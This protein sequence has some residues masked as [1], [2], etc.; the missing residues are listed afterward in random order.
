ME[1]IKSEQLGRIKT[2]YDSEGLIE[3]IELEDLEEIKKAAT[4]KAAELAS[5]VYDEEQIKAAKADRAELNKAVKGLEETRKSIKAKCLAPYES[6]EKQIKELVGIVQKPIAIIDEQVKAFEEKQKL[7]KAAKILEYIGTK[8]LHGIEAEQIRKPEWLNASKS[9]KQ[10]QEEIDKIAEE[11]AAD[12]AIIEDL[13]E[14]RFEALEEYKRTR[15]VRAALNKAK[16]MQEAAKRK[17]EWEAAQKAQEEAQ[18]AALEEVKAEEEKEPENATD[19]AT[20]A[21][22]ELPAFDDDFLPDFNDIP[23]NRHWK[24]I[25]AFV[26]PDQ[27]QAVEE[28]LQRIGAP[29]EIL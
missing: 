5:V 11:I 21:E 29:F 15:D 2:T 13:E 6:F 24:T 7:E 1:I 25:K 8:D 9:M 4:E 28:L 20:E 23:D 19:K 17:A 27:Q 22:E 14:Y 3:K 18:A 12:I 10:V 16:E 26:T